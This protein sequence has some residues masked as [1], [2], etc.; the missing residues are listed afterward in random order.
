MGGGGRKRGRCEKGKVRRGRG[1]K[2]EDGVA[3]GEGEWRKGGKKRMRGGDRKRRGRQ[4]GQVWEG[5]GRG[6]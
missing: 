2:K 4:V 5:E 3:R 1:Q 6:R